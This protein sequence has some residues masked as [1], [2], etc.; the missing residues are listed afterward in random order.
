M[1]YYGRKALALVLSAILIASTAS[2]AFA[3]DPVEKDEVV[4]INL[5]HDG[6]VES[7][8]VVNA[9]D[10]TEE[11]PVTDFGNYR[12]VKNLTTTEELSVQDGAIS[13]TA[14]KGKF[15]YQ[16]E[17]DSAQIPWLVSVTYQL[18]GQPISGGELAGKEG[19]LEMTLS[20]RQNPDANPVYFDNFAIQATVLLDSER[21]KN[22]TAPSATLAN[23][24]GDKQM[25]YIVLP[26]KEKDFTIS[27]DV[28]DFEMDAIQINGIPLTLDIDDPDTT[29]IKDKIYEL[30]D[31]AKELD[32]G[33]FQLDD[34]ATQLQDGALELKDGAADLYDGTDDL[35]DGVKDLDEGADKLRSGAGDLKE[36]ADQLKAGF[37]QLNQ[38]SR[39]LK[40]G[41]AATQQQ[42]ISAL[43]GSGVPIQLPPTP[44]D[45]LDTTYLL[46]VGMALDKGFDLAIGQ[47]E[48]AIKQ[49]E[50]GG[51]SIELAALAPE[52]TVRVLSAAVSVDEDGSISEEGSEDTSSEGSEGNSGD[53]STG[54]GSEGNSGDSSTGE[55]SEGNSGDS[56]T[57]E[58]SEGNSGDSST[59]EGS[60]GNS[61]GNSTGEG[62]SSGEGQL[63]P[64]A[65]EGGNANRPSAPANPSPSF[66]QHQNELADPG[67]QLAILQTQLASLKQFKQVNTLCMGTLQYMAGTEQLSTG[68]TSLY[69]GILEL[70]SGISEL[71]GGVQELL[72]G[73][74]ELFDGA[75]D[76]RDGV[77]ELFDG[78]T[79]LKDGTIELTDGTTE[80]RDQSDEMDSKVDEEIDK[81]LDEYRGGDFDM[82][83]FVSDKNT[84]V[85]SV[86]FVMKVAEI[87]I[88]EEEAPVIQEEV[89]PSFWQK[90][91]NLFK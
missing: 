87:Q 50:S 39:E 68:Y 60:E 26:G 84:Q 89:K 4:Y 14:P 15:Y 71:V 32:D 5:S 81:M 54:E 20:L 33:A 42:M 41:I 59:G 18:D 66:P 73:S 75:S 74:K 17:L 30:K 82:V 85:D 11:Q 19:H 36:G 79:E 9:Y 44:S 47:I 62:S 61:G 77:D 67:D 10:L 51:S 34:G 90:L 58:G 1:K 86:Q 48:A 57:G 21:C 35:Y 43:E 49:L 40:A 88:E 13:F 22:I 52:M 16:G 65:D 12:E 72:D 76:L 45:P 27:A 28:T 37:D 2:T 56:S 55:G 70:R 6:S 78:T 80:L 91:V 3:Q 29:E 8:Y 23:V 46:Q 25:S 53:S 31:G 63:L 7:I 64:P 24:G 83:S 69:D 38:S